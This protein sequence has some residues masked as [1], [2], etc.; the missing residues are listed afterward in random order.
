MTR[1]LDGRV[2]PSR[3]V[4]R[5]GK[6]QIELDQIS[7]GKRQR[8]L[9]NPFT[10]ILDSKWRW[11]FLLF[12][13]GFILTWLLF[14]VIYYI[15]AIV[16]NDIARYG[17]PSHSPCINEVHSFTS[18]FL[19]SLETQH[20]IG[21]GARNPT[22]ECSEAVFVVYLQFIIG[23]AV[24]CLTAGLVLAKLQL[25]K[26]TPNA[27]MFSKSACVGKCND[28][29]CLMV[30]IANAGRSEVLNAKASGV[31]IERLRLETGEEVLSEYVLEFRSESGSSKLNLL[32]PTVIHCQLGD[33]ERSVVKRLQNVRTELIVLI[34]GIL[35]ATGQYVQVRTSYL[36][37][38]IDVG[39]QFVDISPQLEKS[40]DGPA[41]HYSV[42]FA[43][44]HVMVVDELWDYSVWN[45]RNN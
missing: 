12:F 1:T 45:P 35:S 11:T 16:N 9:R 18:A 30:R 14:A 34:E 24:Q 2:G 37:H 22:P 38:E 15:I 43:D 44:F 33:H 21:Y 36:A 26:R 41:Y 40:T 4:N 39:K 32:W 20:T 17:D 42:D 8:Y 5:N 6:L 7:L 28:H 25:G 3:I 31:L 19:F 13:V 23:V 27:I 29:A 10:T